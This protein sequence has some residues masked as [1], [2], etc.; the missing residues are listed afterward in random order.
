MRKFL[1]FIA[2]TFITGSLFAGGLVTN[3]NQSAA[4]VRMPSRNATVGI[5]AV[6]FNP[7]GLTKLEDG[8]HFSV[9]NQTIFQTKT[10]Q[11]SYKGPGGNYGLNKDLYVGKV[12]APIFPSIY[13]VYKTGKLAFSLGF[14][15]VG[16]GGGAVYKTGLPS[17][18]MSASDLVPSLASQN[19]TGYKLD[20]YLKGSSVYFG[21]QGG[22]SYKINDWI[23]VGAGLRYVMGKNTYLGHLTDIQVNLGSVDTP[24]WTRA[25]AIM[26]GIAA[27]A[28]T[29][30]VSTTA[31]VG[32]GAGSITLAT[33][34][35]LGYIT[36]PQ[37]ALLE[38]ALTGFGY[39][40]TVSIATADQIFKGAAVKYT[41]TATLLGDQN[42]DVTQTGSGIS[43]IFSVN[44]SP[45]ENL[46]IGV[47]F[48]MSTKMELVNKTK[49]DFLLAN[50]ATGNITMF[51]DGEKTNSDMPAL[52]SIGA[53]Y[54]VSSSLMLSI[55]GNYFFDKSVSYG[56][57]LDLDINSSTPSTLVRNHDI[58]A[59]NGWSL[60]TGVEANLSEK[61]LVSGGY[62]FANKGV[63]SKYQSDLTYGNATHTIGLGGAY[64]FSKNLQL[65]LGGGYTF[66]QKDSKLVDHIF[67]ATGQ[68]YRPKESYAKKTIMFALGVDFSF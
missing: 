15:P 25:D 51:P 22:V 31:L 30:A 42:V 39:P 28:T 13:G 53:D 12:S 14:N 44:L 34:Q 29:A 19:A 32:A 16:G 46:N 38:G 10:V 1:S 60:E 67:S 26:T 18:E 23:S 41:A 6:Y 66:Y 5:D 35:T 65:N 24:A 37:R 58:I 49:K 40:T 20:A 59:N 63:N 61:L 56:H 52:L 48:E 62:V 21:L 2:A 50:P 47:K 45:T 57:K 3:T 54:K 11:N 55:G 8:F 43:P 68:L 64:S 4:W 36:A 33:A 17:F 9:S 7:A 27:N